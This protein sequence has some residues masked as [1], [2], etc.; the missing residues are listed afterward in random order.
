MRTARSTT[1]VALLPV[2]LLPVTLLLGAPAVILALG[3]LLSPSPASAGNVK[4]K[5]LSDG[6]KVIFN[7]SV[8]QRARRM[9]PNLQAPRADIAFLI[10]H[11]ARLQN[12]NPRLVQAVIQVESGY[13]VRARSRK[14]AMGLMQLMPGTAKQLGVGDPYDPDQNIRGGTQYLSEQLQRFN[15]LSFALAA[16]NA[17][18]EAV[19]QY[20]GIPPYRETRGYVR[21]VMGLI[22][23]NATAGAPSA[24]LQEHARDLARQREL[25]A[26]ARRAE[27]RKQRGAK[28]YLSRDENNRIVFTTAPPKPE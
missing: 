5:T 6:T 28:V 12:L 24:A 22:G 4:V 23:R 3:C 27:E 26:A 10:D 17:G 9:S 13:N 21:K 20:G 1:P 19:S 7:E 8:S 2:T 25:E 15:N 16:Y 14:G 18:P 11:H